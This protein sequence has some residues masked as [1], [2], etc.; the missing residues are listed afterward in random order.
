[1][2]RSSQPQK[3][4]FALVGA[5]VIGKVHAQALADLPD[6]AELV[7]VVDPTRP[8]RRSWPTGTAPR[9]P[10]DLDAVLRRDDI[11]AVTIC[12]PS[13]VHAD[14]A[15]AA[16]DAGKH[17]VVEKPIDITL[18][19]AD[20]IIDAEK[21]SGKTVAVIS[22]HR[23][24][25]STEKVLQAVRDG[26]LGTHHLGDRL[27]RLV[28]R[29]VLLRLRRLARHLGARR[30][31]RRDEPD[32]AHHQPDGHHAR[33]AGRG[34]RLHRVPGARAHRGRGHRRRGGEVR[35]RRAGHH[36]RHHRR[37]P[38]AGRQPA[39]SSDRRARPSSPTTS[40]S[41]STRTPATPP[42]SPC[43]TA[44]AANQVDRRRH[45]GA[46]RPRARHART[47]AS[48]PTSSTPSPTGRPPRV[49][50]AEART[51]LS[52]I[53]AMYESAP[54]AG[55]S[56][57]SRDR[58]LDD[59]SQRPAPGRQ[60]H[61]LL[62]RRAAPRTGPPARWARRSP[63]WPRS[64]TRR[65][66]RTCPTTWRPTT[67]CRWLASFGLEPALSLY[68][69]SFADRDTHEEQAEAA[70]G[71][72][73]PAGDVRPAVLHDL[74]DRAARLPRTGPPRGG[75][76]L[77]PGPARGRRRRHRPVLRGDARRGGHRRPAPAR[78]RLGGD[79][80]RAAR[81]AGRRRPGPARLRAGHRAHVVGGHGRAR[82]A[83]RLRRPH[84]R[85][86]PQGHLRRRHRRGARPTTSTTRRRPS[87]A[88]SGPSRASATSTWR[89]A[90]R[91]SPPTSPA[92][93]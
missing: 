9:P 34:V 67:T 80:A 73:G 76:R 8:R 56:R 48:S 78:R 40:W 24:D 63:S 42:K 61:R 39:R 44:T 65:S 43:R 23:F 62:A 69:G 49:G 13:G 5:G 57:C 15:V 21:R 45:A 37:L 60:P 55:P 75:P 66:R 51:A 18:A 12:T 1:M 41:S 89:P 50:T 74:D 93:T 14:V 30:R 11:D 25:K 47:A 26:H 72:R 10:T 84:R 92:T 68:S 64:A 77:R 20:R 46:G 3:L 88:G 79:R 19:A 70:P 17:V 7:A 27:A 91:R 36:P 35:L 28:A 82:G 4:R 54:P 31:R 29:T 2:P 32:R 16:L 87:R 22:Q 71:L 38:R 81:G 6:V 85:G 90:S 53:L 52:V 86:A 83:A 33:H 59:R 58:G